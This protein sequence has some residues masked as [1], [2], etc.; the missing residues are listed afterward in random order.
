[1]RAVAPIFFLIW[2]LQH[3]ELDQQSK[4]M[5]GSRS[6]PWHVQSS[7]VLHFSGVYV[8]GYYASCVDLG[9]SQQCPSP[10]LAQASSSD[11]QCQ[12]KVLHIVQIHML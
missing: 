12:T 2:Q 9:I 5:Q 1:M 11:F 6:R 4:C 3:L 7:Q 10:V 8:S